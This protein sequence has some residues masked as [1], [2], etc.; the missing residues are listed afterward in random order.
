MWIATVPALDDEEHVVIGNHHSADDAGRRV[1][2]ALGGLGYE[3]DEGV[4]H[5]L[6]FDLWARCE[7]VGD[8]LSVLLLTSP[9]VLD[10]MVRT[11]PERLREAVASLRG[12]PPVDGGVPLLR[13]EIT[14]D[15]DPATA[16]GGDQVVVL[17]HDG[18]ATP[19][20]LL[21][22]F[23]PEEATLVVLHTN[24]GDERGGSSPG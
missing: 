19:T 9:G 8:R 21:A 1:V 14:T 22:E 23:D 18:V 10:D 6:A 16:P 24:P 2:G 5:L 7:R 13:R 3:G 4:Y 17:D 11:C 12:T 15:F 20:D